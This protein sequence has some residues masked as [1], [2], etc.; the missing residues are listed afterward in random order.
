MKSSICS[1]CP[2]WASRQ[3]WKACTWNISEEY[4]SR[5]RR[6]E[7]GG[8]WELQPDCFHSL[9]DELTM[10]VQTGYC[11]GGN[12]SFSQLKELTLI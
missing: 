4:S 11:F 8:T 12:E 1:G 10:T 3:P 9:K 2:Q 5:A 6:P 7:A